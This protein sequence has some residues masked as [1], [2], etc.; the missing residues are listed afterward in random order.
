[1]FELNVMQ[2]TFY[3]RDNI[4]IQQQLLMQNRNT[5]LH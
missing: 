4:K 5:K 1:M 3:M 2:I